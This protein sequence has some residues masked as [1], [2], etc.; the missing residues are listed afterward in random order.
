MTNLRK[1]MLEELE[2]R[3]YSE[4]TTR[5]YLRFVE[6]FAQHFGKPPDKLGPDHLR[7]YQAYLL[8]VRKLDP[9]TVENHVAA[10]RFLFIRTL[11]ARLSPRRNP[12]RHAPRRRRVPAPILPAC[13]APGFRAHPPLRPTVEPLPKTDAAPGT[14]PARRSGPR[15]ATASASTRLRSLA[16]S[17]LRRTYARRRTLHRRS[18]LLHRLRFFMTR[19]ANPLCRFAPC[20]RSRSCAH[21]IPQPFKA[22]LTGRL[23]SR[24]ELKLCNCSTVPSTRGND[25]ALKGSLLNQEMAFNIHNPGITHRAR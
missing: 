25:E 24:I 1:M 19:A 16:L 11:H 2:R 7:T 8:K 12:A 5:R 17:P 13:I 21:L 23:R 6:R 9:G 18:T 14:H 4:C 22:A 15:A 10:L 20:T 3:N